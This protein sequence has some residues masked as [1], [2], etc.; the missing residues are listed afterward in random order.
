MPS[1]SR[2]TVEPLREDH[3]DELYEGFLDIATYRFIPTINYVAPLA[4]EESTSA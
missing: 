4:F 1:T 3:A 2:L